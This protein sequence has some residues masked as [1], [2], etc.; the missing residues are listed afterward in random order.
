MAL[1]AS[2][3][4]LLGRGVK[5]FN[6]YQDEDIGLQAKRLNLLGM[7]Q[8]Q[9]DDNALRAATKSFGTD[10]GVNRD[11]LAKTG[12]YKALSAFDKAALDGQKTRGE[13]TKDAATAGHLTAQTGDIAI[14]QKIAAHDR[15]LA[16]LGT[17]TDP[18]QIDAWAAQ[19]VQDGVLG[20]QASMQGA[21][22]MK[23]FAAKYGFEAA[24]QQALRGGMSAKD[25]LEQQ[26]KE[27]TQKE[28]G[29]HNLSTEGIQAANLTETTRNHKVHEGLT[30]R[31]QNM[32][33]ARSRE[34]DRR[35]D[36]QAVRGHGPGW[37]TDAR[38]AGPPGQHHA[39]ARLRPEGGLCQAAHRHAGQGSRLRHA[40]AGGRQDPQRDRRRLQ[41]DGRQCQER[42]EHMPVVG[43][44]LEPLA[45]KSMSDNSQKAEQAQR[46]FV[47]AVL[48]RESGAAISESEFDNARRQYFPESGDSK[49]KARAEGAQS[50]AR[51]RGRD[52]RSAEG[53][54]RLH[55]PAARPPRRSAFSAPRLMERPRSRPRPGRR[56]S[57]DL[58]KRNL[59]FRS[60]RF[61][62]RARAR[63]PSRSRPPRTGSA[64]NPTAGNSFGQNVRSRAS[65]AA[66]P[67][68]GAGSVGLSASPRKPTLT[69]PS[70]STLR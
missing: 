42:A 33:D 29:R 59:E 63:R 35:D 10:E 43:G 19:G 62:H 53:P 37:A 13:I 16:Q 15:H 11:L 56:S 40:D 67:R 68:P 20:M 64:Y 50:Q 38:A 48:R 4:N 14:K 69:K 5:S 61:E 3:Y 65:G 34:S 52:G 27:G 28:T 36:D 6:E 17:L 23:D 46:D 32:T 58:N 45:N 8:A 21:Q 49:R 60:R 1:D 31:G 2:I 24:K 70:A 22:Q 30:I 39:R 26:L 25:Q 51:S 18:S 41:P 12:N 9:E 54:A 55:R 66:C 47:N 57:N 44:A 7:K